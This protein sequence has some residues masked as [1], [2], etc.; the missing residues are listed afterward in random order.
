MT[1]SL[2][3]AIRPATDLLQYQVDRYMRKMM[4]TDSD[5]APPIESSLCAYDGTGYAAWVGRELV[6]VATYDRMRGIDLVEPQFFINGGVEPSWR[7]RGFGGQL[8]EKLMKDM[9]SESPAGGVTVYLPAVSTEVK[10]GDS[11]VELFFI[12]RRFNQIGAHIFYEGTVVDA[13]QRSKECSEKISTQLYMGGDLYQSRAISELHEIS[14][15][16]SDGYVKWN[17]KSIDQDLDSTGAHFVLLK[18]NEDFVGYARCA[19]RYSTYFIGEIAIAR[20]AWGKVSSD[21]LANAIAKD[22]IRR[23]CN[24]LAGF[25][26]YNNRA[27]RSFNERYGLSPKL[28]YP[29][30]YYSWKR[31][32]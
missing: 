29:R 30:M 21:G 3:L 26:D 22:A 7:K 11:E 27:A 9:K 25:V 23:G 20:K 28:S 31:G 1:T 4:P 17:E 2:S 6:A 12:H 18:M 24:K 13:E 19:V 10:A 8:L 15:S 14:F 5:L 32:N 16:R